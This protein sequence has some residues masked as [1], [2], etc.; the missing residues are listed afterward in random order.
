MILKAFAMT[1]LMMS[2]AQAHA[3]AYGFSCANAEGSIRIGKGSASILVA[4]LIGADGQPKE[5]E[6]VSKTL[7]DYG[8][9]SSDEGAIRIEVK[10]KK[11]RLLLKRG[12]TPCG[13]AK[14]TEVFVAR[15]EIRD[16][17]SNKLIADDHV[18]CRDEFEGGHC[19]GESQ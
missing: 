4:D 2:G 9:E 13:D 12:K 3:G 10:G 5:V 17:T 16:L 18:I 14:Q 15:I 8:L 1:V 7:N 6:Y 19:I 11:S